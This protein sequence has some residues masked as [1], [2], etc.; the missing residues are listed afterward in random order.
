MNDTYEAIDST[1][2]IS[3][4]AEMF[5]GFSLP[6]VAILSV[7]TVIFAVPVLSALSLN[8]LIFGVFPS[9]TPSTSTTSSP[10]VTVH[11]RGSSAVL[12]DSS[13]ITSDSFLSPISSIYLLLLNERTDAGDDTF[14]TNEAFTG[15]ALSVI[16]VIVAKPLFF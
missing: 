12:G 13:T 6:S 14:T 11:T 16:A 9:D 8:T 10:S 4:V 7:L 15:S 5:S 2:S 3:H 1:T